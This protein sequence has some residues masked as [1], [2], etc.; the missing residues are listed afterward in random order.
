V[1][2]VMGAWCVKRKSL[3]LWIDGGTELLIALISRNIF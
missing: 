1:V 3:R 2:V